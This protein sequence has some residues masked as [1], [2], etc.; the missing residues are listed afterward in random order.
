MRLIVFIYIA[1]GKQA[2]DAASPWSRRM[3]IDIHTITQSLLDQALAGKV[4]EATIPGTGKD[5][6]PACAT[7]AARW[8]A[9]RT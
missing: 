5:G 4:L 9:A 3:K 6:T 2:G 8:C 1:I 7:V